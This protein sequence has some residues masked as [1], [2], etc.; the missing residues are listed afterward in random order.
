MRC[1][2]LLWASAPKG[3]YHPIKKCMLFYEESKLEF[4]AVE[5]VL[6]TGGK[7]S[8][9]VGFL[10]K[11]LLEEADNFHGRLLQVFEF[12]ADSSDTGLTRKNKIYRGICR[13]HMIDSDIVLG[14]P[15]EASED[16]N[17]SWD[18]SKDEEEELLLEN[19]HQNGPKVQN[20]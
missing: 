5:A 9:R 1:P 3:L 8:C 6:V 17:E 12:L 13:A 4:E 14:L 11:Y 2:H 10:P 20:K 16:P 19:N 7:D 18:S 15:C